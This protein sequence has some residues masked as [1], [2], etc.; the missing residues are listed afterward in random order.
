MRAG[1]SVFFKHHPGRSDVGEDGLQPRM[2]G[3]VKVDAVRVQASFSIVLSV[4]QSEDIMIFSFQNAAVGDD[5]RAP[6]SQLDN[7]HARISSKNRWHV[8]S[9]RGV[10]IHGCSVK[11][12]G[13]KDGSTR[14]M[15]ERETGLTGTVSGRY[16]S[17]GE[18]PLTEF[19]LS[20]TVNVSRRS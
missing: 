12:H 3:Y 8:W 18:K 16:R 11:W 6:F 17:S 20:K 14:M 1:Y 5:R 19:N 13:D 7:I 4:E 9:N 2:T 15:R 10:V